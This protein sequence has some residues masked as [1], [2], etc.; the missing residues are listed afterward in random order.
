[1][2]AFYP[3]PIRRLLLIITFGLVLCVGPEETQ[4]DPID[5]IPPSATSTSITLTWTAPGDDGDHGLAAIYDLRVSTVPITPDN[6]DYAS[7]VIDIPPPQPAGTREMLTITNLQPDTDYYLALKVG[8]EVPNWSHLSNTV[9]RR[10]ARAD[11]AP[12]ADFDCYPTA[13]T[14]PLTVAFRDRSLHEPSSWDWDFGDGGRSTSGNPIHVYTLPGDYSVSLKV[15]NLAGD[16]EITKVNIISVEDATPRWYAVTEQTIAGTATGALNSLRVLDGV[17]QTV[18]ETTEG[19]VPGQNPNCLEHRWKFITPGSVLLRL[20]VDAWRNVNADGDDFAF[21]Y[22]LDNAHYS[23]LLIVDSDIPEGRLA[24]IPDLSRDSI[25]IRVVDTNRT[26]GFHTEDAVHIDRL[27][28]STHEQTVAPVSMLVSGLSVTRHQ[29]EP[30][31]FRGQARVAV[32]SVAGQ[33]VQSA[34]IVGSFTGPTVDRVSGVTGEDGTVLLH[35]S[36]AG[37]PIERWCFSIDSVIRGRDVYDQTR[38]LISHA[39]ESDP[40]PL[41]LKPGLLK[42]AQNIPNP[43]N[44]ITEI[45][46]TLP[47]TEKATLAVYNILGQHVT[48]LVNRVVD[49][50]SHRV[51]WEASGSASGVYFYRL[52]TD[53]GVATRKMMLLR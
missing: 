26:S 7:R 28:L 16:G 30:G 44:P 23:R 35:S 47:Q 18:T 24:D 36:A 49:A 6:W 31:V 40:A 10:T 51:I 8:D 48:T 25:F 9:H 3:V 1:M 37:E 27:F 13:G 52:S 53:S 39:S 46:F 43:F 21:G 34:R 38:N 22:S 17:C 41:V 20:N 29:I 33:P 19:K 5:T 45:E 15:S 4:A 2:L 42:L 32:Q 12:V 14:A 11:V 50:G